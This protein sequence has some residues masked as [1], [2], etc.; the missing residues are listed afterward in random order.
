MTKI[1]EW[2]VCMGLAPLTTTDIFFSFW[3]TV[4]CD[5]THSGSIVQPHHATL[6][7]L[8][9]II[10]NITTFG[11]N[12]ELCLSA[13]D[14]KWITMLVPISS[15][16]RS[17][18]ELNQE[19][20]YDDQQLIPEICCGFILSPECNWQ[21]ALSF[22]VW[23][24]YVALQL[25]DP[26]WT[27]QLN[28]HCTYTT[29]GWTKTKTR[30]YIIW[31]MMVVIHGRYTS[32]AG[33]ISKWWSEQQGHTLQMMV[34]MNNEWYTSLIQ[35]WVPVALYC[36]IVCVPPFLQLG[37]FDA[38]RSS[39]QGDMVLDLLRSEVLHRHNT[40]VP[41]HWIQ[42]GRGRGGIVVT[43]FPGMQL[44]WSQICEQSRWLTLPTNAKSIWELDQ[45]LLSFWGG[46]GYARL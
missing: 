5:I 6:C 24:P 13:I 1:A 12:W 30:N 37:H 15:L 40:T 42:D 8:E 9:T 10:A 11:R 14:S 18:R 3:P 16:T 36:G 20:G 41:I 44:T 32:L 26:T 22:P 4:H 25:V 39:Q 31:M 23:G 17:S 34:V 2:M 29:S 21:I 45:T 33:S 7:R 28:W 35:E 38:R 19:K 46:S 27:S 43:L